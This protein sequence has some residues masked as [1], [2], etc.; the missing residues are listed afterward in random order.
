MPNDL[1]STILKAIMSTS[2]EAAPRLR[3]G[4]PPRS[5]IQPHGDQ[6]QALMRMTGGAAVLGSGAYTW[7]SNRPDINKSRKRK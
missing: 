4:A 1:R 6:T 2:G 7:A 3:R 5:N